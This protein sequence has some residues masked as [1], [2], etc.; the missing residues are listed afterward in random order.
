MTVSGLNGAGA[1]ARTSATEPPTYV[2]RPGDTLSGIAAAHG[3]SLEA[4]QAANPQ[5]LHHDL[6]RAGQTLH[7]PETQAHP[8]AAPAQGSYTVKAGDTLSAIGARF[9]S[10]RGHVLAELAAENR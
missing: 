1:P 4:L 3:V 9:V 5:V 2:V 8:A 7:L 6:I 10:E